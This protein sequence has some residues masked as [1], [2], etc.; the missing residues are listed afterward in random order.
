MRRLTKVKTRYRKH[1]W[2]VIYGFLEMASAF[3]AI[4]VSLAIIGL[5]IKNVMLLGLD[6][7]F[8]ASV[9]IMRGASNL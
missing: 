7:G 6:T 5:D 2:K 1:K 8:S 9:A 4:G 3:F